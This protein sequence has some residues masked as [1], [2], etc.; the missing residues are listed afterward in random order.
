MAETATPTT[1]STD[2]S[3]AGKV[4]LQLKRLSVLFPILR[5]KRVLANEGKGYLLPRKGEET[6]T[7][8]SQNSFSNSPLLTIKSWH[9]NTMFCGFLSFALHSVL[10]ADY[11]AAVT[12]M[13]NN[14]QEF[15]GKNGLKYYNLKK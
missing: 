1:T 4:S 13:N 11:T 8:K 9:R 2:Q 6:K 10:T 3:P 15:R 5:I 12:R 7:L 14:Y